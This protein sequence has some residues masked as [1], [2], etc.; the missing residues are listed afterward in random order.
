MIGKLFAFGIASAAA[1]LAARHLID[2]PEVIDQLPEGA[3][4]PARKLREQLIEV[5]A[6]LREVIE[7]MAEERRTAEDDLRSEFLYRAR[8]PA[9]EE[10][11]S[12]LGS[13]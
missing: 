1:Y 9:P 8:R 12:G 3:Q 2:Q 11:P 6:V 4:E 5:D 7:E 10:N 13:I